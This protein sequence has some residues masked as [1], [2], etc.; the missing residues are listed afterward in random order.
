MKKIRNII[1]IL[2]FAICMMLV[3]KDSAYAAS[4][5]D[6][7]AN[8]K[9]LK[10]GQAVA[11]SV[12]GKNDADYYKFKVE[13]TGCFQLGVYL[14]GNSLTDDI[15]HGW[16][17]KIYSET[18][19]YNCIR[20]YDSITSNITTGK[21]ALPKG[22]YYVVITE[23]NSEYFPTN[24]CEYAIKADYTVDSHW[25][26]ESN[27]DNRIPTIIN[28]NEQYKGVHNVSD[29]VDWYK[30]TTVKD[31]KFSVT[32]SVDDSTDVEEINWGWNL[33]IYD[34]SF[35][36]I[37][38]YESVNRTTTTVELPFEKG[39]YYVKVRMQSEYFP[40][41][42]CVYGIKVNF[43]TPARWESEKN[44]EKKFADI[45]KVN[46]VWNGSA[47]NA[48]D[49]DWYKVQTTKAGYF[50]VEFVVPDYVDSEKVSWGWNVTVYD[51]NSNEI[52]KLDG[53]NGKA[54]T[55]ILPYGKDTFYIKVETKSEY[56][57]PTDCDYTL[58]VINIASSNF[59]S[60]NNDIKKKADTITLGKTY[61]GV[62]NHAKDED[63]YKFNVAKNG[64]VKFGLNKHSSASAD[65]ILNGWNVTV[66]DKNNKEVAKIENIKS[67]GTANLN[68]K[69]GIYYVKVNTQS[70]YFPPAE[71]RYTISTKFVPAPASS[72]ITS[73]K[74]KAK[75]VTLKWK[76]S[77]DATG[78]Y[79]YRSESK[80]G[81]YKKIATVKGAKKVSYT[82]KK[83]LKK[84][85]VYYYKVVAYKT[86]N[87]INAP[88]KEGNIKNVKV[89]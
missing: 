14:T 33:T 74:Y 21:M 3:G 16:N 13:Q 22:N 76:K 19:I 49:I 84:G 58:K 83:G 80:K 26:T 7:K 69:K 54:R 82:D 52:K 87:K 50:Q 45:I 6:L 75:K 10:Y 35:K 85:Q 56:F 40:C 72:K 4:L 60:E 53:V 70:S 55:V 77:A 44:D 79:I 78:Y 57:P 32:L 68:L 67:K 34:S 28:V 43:S 47:Y 38:K 59:E 66:Y 46:E 88:A 36:E 51:K 18:D 73:I 63:W 5:A 64:T 71:C 39:T 61:N 8:A 42:D 65:D 31:G 27:N 1:A 20:E 23:Q 9:E 25:E 86:T 41:Q 62:T 29:D 2:T 11:G 12:S 24:N 81:E 48:K 15:G 30:F 89:R 17:V 37:K